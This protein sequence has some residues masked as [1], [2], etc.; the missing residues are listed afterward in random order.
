MTARQH[1]ALIKTC[2]VPLRRSRSPLSGFSSLNDKEGFY[3]VL[4]LQRSSL[5]ET[6]TIFS[7]YLRRNKRWTILLF[8][9][10]R[11]IKAGSWISRIL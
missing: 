3:R 7:V 11:C 4:L 9:M 10:K 2:C 5:C 1:N 6:A 8:V